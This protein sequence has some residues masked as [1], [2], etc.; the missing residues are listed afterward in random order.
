MERQLIKDRDSLLFRGIGAAT[1]GLVALCYPGQ[2]L[3]AMMMP[4]GILLTISGLV[5]VAKNINPLVS[6]QYQECPLSK[7][8]LAELLLGSLAIV[9]AAFSVQLFWEILAAWLIITGIANVKRYSD[10]RERMPA[11][12]VLLIAN[13]LSVLFGLFLVIN[14][15]TGLVTL[16]YEAVGLALL[17][18]GSLFYTYFKLGELQQ[19]MG[20]RPGKIH[21]KKMTVY[22]DR[23][24]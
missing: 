7:K 4:F 21:S 20:H 12:K 11:I 19:Y 18:G 13:V 6:H 17:L 10:L 16:T 22:Y 1:F 2:A 8:G 5:T 9:A 3:Q 23:T 14:L 15:L 24:Y